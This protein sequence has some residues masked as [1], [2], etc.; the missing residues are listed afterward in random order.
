M[1]RINE[2][3]NEEWATDKTRHAVDGLVR[4]R[5][6]KPYVRKDGKLVAATLGRSVRCDRGGRRRARASPRSPAIWS[7][8]RRCIAAKA[9]LASMGSTL[10]EGRQTGMDYDTS[11]LAAVN[12]NTTIAGTEK[13]DVILLV[14]TNLRW[15]APLV[16]TRIRKAIKKGAKVFAIGPETELTY[17]VEWL[18]DDLAL[19]GNLPEAAT[20]A[21][22]EGRAADGDRRRRGAQGRAR[23]RA[24]AGEAAGPGRRT[25]GTASTSCTWRRAGWAG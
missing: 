17:K 10:L 21:F 11:S 19:L 8:A 5:L 24:G 3:V 25:A 4:R 13:A 1:P 22:G 7:I 18:G 2:D 9:L 6:D 12:F 14:G 20:E 16:N 23:R 15:E